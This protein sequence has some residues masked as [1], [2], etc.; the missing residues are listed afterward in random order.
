MR[1]N[2][3]E[4]H[5]QIASSNEQSIV[6][7]ILR[8]AMKGASW[9]AKEK[10]E[11]RR[12]VLTYNKSKRAETETLWLPKK[13]AYLYGLISLHWTLLREW[14]S[15]KQ[16][17]KSKKDIKRALLSQHEEHYEWKYISDARSSIATW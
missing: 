6:T 4:K 7:F 17:D 1:R 3:S 10:P 9:K 12:K 5:L 16:L 11:N 2:K 8:Q 15:W 13:Y 14:R